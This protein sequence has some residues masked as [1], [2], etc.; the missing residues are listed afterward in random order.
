M[1]TQPVSLGAELG[2]GVQAPRLLSPGQDVH[3]TTQRAVSK[4]E[5]TPGAQIHFFFTTRIFHKLNPDC[6]S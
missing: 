5:D 6:D 1:I 4:T 2:W 3:V